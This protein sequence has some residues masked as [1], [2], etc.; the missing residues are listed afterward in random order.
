MKNSKILPK[1]EAF[2]KG[3]NWCIDFN[4]CTPEN[5]AFIENAMEQFFVSHKGECKSL[6]E[7]FFSQKRTYFPTSL[8]KHFLSQEDVFLLSII[9]QKELFNDELFMSQL[10][11]AN[12]TICSPLVIELKTFLKNRR[13][14]NAKEL[15]I[16]Q[17]ITEIS[18]EDLIF[19][20]SIW[21]DKVYIENVPSIGE[22]QPISVVM[23]AAFSFVIQ[24]KKSIQVNSIQ[25]EVAPL[26]TFKSKLGT[27]GINTYPSEFDSLHKDD[28]L[29]LLMQ[30]KY[31]YMLQ[32]LAQNPETFEE[33]ETMM[34]DVGEIVQ[35]Q[36]LEEDYLF[37]NGQLFEDENGNSFFLPQNTEEEYLWQ[38][39]GKVDAFLQ[40]YYHLKGQQMLAPDRQNSPF[41]E[42]TNPAVALRWQMNGFP[43]EI[44]WCIK[45][46]D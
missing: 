33:F 31:F 26:E 39:T 1:L 10:E 17:K 30:A 29:A 27:F 45:I 23:E 44:W 19:M 46:V 15:L 6:I 13:R 40:Q 3:Q 43:N 34:N 22:H 37:R 7:R 28:N 32:D 8:L 21:L 25:I 36:M 18:F 4:Q 2:F 20:L 16:K 14:T 35:W 12:K 11:I 24:L 41:I 42:V 38:K 9:K 5:I